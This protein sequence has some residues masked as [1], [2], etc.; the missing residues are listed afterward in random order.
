ML[1]DF[2]SYNDKINLLPQEARCMNIK[3][4]FQYLDKFIKDEVQ[5]EEMDLT[6]LP[7]HLIKIETNTAE[8]RYEITSTR[9]LRYGYNIEISIEDMDSTKALQ[10]KM[11]LVTD[12]FIGEVRMFMKRFFQKDYPLNHINNPREHMINIGNKLGDTILSLITILLNTVKISY[13]NRDYAK[14]L[15]INELYK[16]A[17]SYCFLGQFFRIRESFDKT[18]IKPAMYYPQLNKFMY[19]IVQAEETFNQEEQMILKSKIID[20]IHFF[21]FEID[22]DYMNQ[23]IGKEASILDRIYN[24]AS[25][26]SINMRERVTHTICEDEAMEKMLDLLIDYIRGNREDNL[27]N[28]VTVFASF[29]YLLNSRIMGKYMYDEDY[30]SEL[31]NYKN[32]YDDKIINYLEVELL[33]EK[34]TYYLDLVWNQKWDKAINELSNYGIPYYYKILD[35]LKDVDNL[36]ILNEVVDRNLPKIKEYI[37]RL[38]DYLYNSLYKKEKLYLPSLYDNPLFPNVDLKEVIELREKRVM[39]S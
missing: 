7:V 39:K 18:G 5:P 22:Y 15:M 4:I 27:N 30:I 23:T 2:S 26:Y 9:V 35:I 16:A 21:R 3:E 38:D 12:L 25:D 17:K 24:V 32:L 31:Y 6:T 10:Y 37:E 33:D 36:E 11:E 14:N 19:S 13:W 8:T 29:Q 28:V 34:F 1:R 20:I